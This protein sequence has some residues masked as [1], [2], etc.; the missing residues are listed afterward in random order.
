MRLSPIRHA[1][2]SPIMV[3]IQKKRVCTHKGKVG[4]LVI[5]IPSNEQSYDL[6]Y[7]V[8]KLRENDSL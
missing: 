2:T 4:N 5:R 7:T 3:C 8:R 1:T 6:N